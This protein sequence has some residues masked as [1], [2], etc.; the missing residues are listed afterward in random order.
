MDEFH[1]TDA[2]LSGL[3]VSIYVL[4]CMSPLAPP[5]PTERHINTNRTPSMEPDA[6]GPILIA[7]LSELYGRVPL[8]NATNILFVI[9]TVACG[10][11]KSL[12][13]LI[14]FRFLQGIAGSAAITMGAG[15][16]ADMFVPEERG[17]AIGI[18]SMGPL[19][20]PVRLFLVY[21]PCYCG[22]IPVFLSISLCLFPCCIFSWKRH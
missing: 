20:G 6:F 19:L 3:I 4:G 22:F 11:S 15:T 10:V 8:Y 9:F 18:W 16:C 7:P 21:L 5:Q 13:S 17:R 12:A 14:G 2:I 1:S